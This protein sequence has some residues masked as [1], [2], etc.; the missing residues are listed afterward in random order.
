VSPYF[1]RT[2]FDSTYFDTD[3]VTNGGGHAPKGRPT[4]FVP[5]PPDPLRDDEDLLWI[6]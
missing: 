6:T 5:A 4:R 2:Y 1:D 3:T